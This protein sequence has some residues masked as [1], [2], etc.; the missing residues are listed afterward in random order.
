M[1]RRQLPGM[2]QDRR[3]N[4]GYA[5]GQADLVLALMLTE[6]GRA[7]LAGLAKIAAQGKAAT[8]SVSV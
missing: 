2:A 4:A 1:A 5:E 6:E 7:A 3:H 8:G